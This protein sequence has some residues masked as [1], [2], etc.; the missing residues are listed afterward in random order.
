M[1]AR[2]QPKRIPTP[3]HA[4]PPALRINR[5][6]GDTA[7]LERLLL[8]LAENR[9]GS[10]ARLG[11]ALD[12]LR[13]LL[14]ASSNGAAPA[15]PTIQSDAAQHIEALEERVADLARRVQN[16]EAVESPSG[17]AAAQPEL[18]R[19]FQELNAALEA[20]LN[21]PPAPV[22]PVVDP[23]PSA[24]GLLEVQAI[25][26][27]LKSIDHAVYEAGANVQ[28][29]QAVEAQLAELSGAIG[30]LGPQIEQ[31]A[32]RS[33]AETVS[34]I[35]NSEHTTDAIARFDAIRQD[36][37]A[38]TQ[39]AGR[40]D[41]RTLETLE[42]I[43]G[44]LQH[45]AQR[46]EAAEAGA[47]DKTQG[48][49]KPPGDSR[50]ATQPGDSRRAMNNPGD[51]RR[52]T[53]NPGDS[54]R[55]TNKE[56]EPVASPAP[57]PTSQRLA[58]DVRQPGDSRQATNKPGDSRQ[59]S[60]KPGDSRRASNKPGDSRQDDKKQPEPV[61]SPSPALAPRRLASDAKK[62]GK[63]LVIAAVA[64]LILSAGLL[65]GRLNTSTGGP[66]GL[67]HHLAPTPAEPSADH[68]GSHAGQPGQ[69]GGGA[70]SGNP[71]LPAG[72]ENTQKPA[73]KLKTIPA[74]RFDRASLITADPRPFAPGFIL[75][76]QSH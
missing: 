25:A 50:R 55:V 30:T 35:E 10:D 17:E 39:R 19:Q 49:E 65:Y 18:D 7:G 20:S 72:R 62:P 68:E 58:N 75:K 42:T 37:Q 46:I 63:I 54:R 51:S 33:A 43:S 60:N 74:T 53:N 44:T 34:Q 28:R 71:E 38:L 4:E 52:A 69:G 1:A 5:A 47:M 27:R 64:L 31:I 59:A 36:L 16:S 45:L 61:T 66:P 22:P 2:T 21:M 70:E 26:D 13:A 41:E 32:G 24:V 48:E 40:M 11:A 29:I 14:R 56:P 57:A 8:Q 15:Q 12:E 76:S 73:P 23:S 67:D 3:P 6:H 9:A